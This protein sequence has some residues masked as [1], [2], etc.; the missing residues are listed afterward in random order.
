M[1]E[2]RKKIQTLFVCD[3]C[4]EEYL[5]WQGQCSNC[6]NWNSLREF[7]HESPRLSGRSG[8][9]DIK[10][11][12]RLDFGKKDP[13]GRIK[14]EIRELDRVLGGGFVHG[15]VV[16]LGGDPGIGKSTLSLELSKSLSI[17]YISGEESEAQISIRASRIQALEKNLLFTSQTD[18]NSIVEI[19]DR[20]KE[21]PDLVVIDSIQTLF[22]P[23]LPSTPGSL[24]QVRES[25]VRLTELAKQKNQTIMLIG[26]VTKEGEV[27]G[28]RL[29]EHLVDVVLYLEGERYHNAR[30]LRAV[31]NRFGDVSEVGVFEMT[32]QG[33]KEIANPSK[34]FLAERQV[35]TPGNVVSATLY[36]SRPILVEI[37]ALTNR[38]PFGYPKRTASGFDL[39]RLAIIAAILERRAGI[40]LSDQDIFINVV[41]GFTVRDPAADLAVALAIASSVKEKAL[42]D[43]ICVFGELGLGGEIRT[44]I[45]ADRRLKE[46]RQLG[47]KKKIE[48][49]NLKSA[50]FETGLATRS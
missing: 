35:E 36:G 17:L 19:L 23:N 27:A 18:V 22:D 37:Q 21:R 34:L 1:A 16:L 41:G 4:G 25:A 10:Q 11:P 9:L 12:Q 5:R 49:K 38:T 15:S 32:E 43:E 20:L 2:R 44:V 28:P 33:L 39:S 48:A 6:Q 24:V 30:V 8:S 47:L 40:K 42:D 45:Q 14:T 29:L 50:F 3:D 46:A 13:A 7:R 31:K 26:H